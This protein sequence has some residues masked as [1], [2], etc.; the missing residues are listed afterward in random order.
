M[1]SQLDGKVKKLKVSVSQAQARRAW[2]R[3]LSQIEKEVAERKQE[4]DELAA[5][6]SDKKEKLLPRT[7][8]IREAPKV[9]ESHKGELPEIRES[10][11]TLKENL[12]AVSSKAERYRWALI[13]QL[14]SVYPIHPTKDA[15]IY[16]ICGTKLPNSLSFSGFDVDAVS[17]GL[18]YVCHLVFHLSKF[19]GICLKSPLKPCLTHSS[20]LAEMSPTATEFPLCMKGSEKMH[21][22]YGVY[23][24]NKNIEQVLLAIGFKK[25]HMKNTLPNL[26]A[27]YAMHCNR[28]GRT[29]VESRPEPQALLASSS[30]KKPTGTSS[31]D[32][33][34]DDLPPVRQLVLSG[35]DLDG[36]ISL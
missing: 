1:K 24:L 29:R 19:L 26:S 16:Q 18:G 30:G 23:L 17:T 14:Y 10:V 7:A 12:Q 27:I 22:E 3:E 32:L 36:R 33:D 6:V 13:T 8:A 15:D 28:Q 35:D 5:A 11:E 4:C 21:F 2:A 25:T 31:P 34:D 9:L 20:V